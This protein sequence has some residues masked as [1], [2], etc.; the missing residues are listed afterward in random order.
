MLSTTNVFIIPL[1]FSFYKSFERY[2]Y[3][4]NNFSYFTTIKR[5]LFYCI[6]KGKS[7]S[8]KNNNFI[9]RNSL[10]EQCV[11]ILKI[12]WNFWN[13]TFL[14]AE[15]MVYWYHSLCHYFNREELKMN[16]RN[17][18]QKWMM[19]RYGNDSLNKMLF[20][21]LI[22]FNF[23]SPIFRLFLYLSIIICPLFFLRKPAKRIE[24][25]CCC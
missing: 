20:V 22:F 23:S 13:S 12:W 24:P 18:L 1:F 6:M 14:F 16:F 10:F 9:P 21:I 8:S 11:L 17:T 5:F 19:G 2:F 15:N 7:L 3:L 4:S 25:L